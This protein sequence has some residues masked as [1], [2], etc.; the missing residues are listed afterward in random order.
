M[1]FGRKYAL[2][3][4]DFLILRYKLCYLNLI[5]CILSQ[6]KIYVEMSFL[7]RWM[8]QN[9]SYLLNRWKRKKARKK[10]HNLPVLS[11]YT[12]ILQENDDKPTITHEW[13]A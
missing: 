7:T 5:M 3:F 2:S 1:D 6:I 9:L 10:L 8:Y 12:P 13:H 11:Y 4:S